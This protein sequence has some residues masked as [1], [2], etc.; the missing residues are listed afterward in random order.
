MKI[1]ASVSIV[2]LQV[3]IEIPDSTPVS[4]IR[5]KVIE[6]ARHLLANNGGEHVVLEASIAELVD[7]V[8]RLSRM[9]FPVVVEF[10][11]IEPEEPDW[12]EL[13]EYGVTR[14]QDH[15]VEYD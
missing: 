5:D 7:G 4:E 15:R 12:N 6:Q 14:S 11:E 8:G 9:G 3:I 2:P 13:A 1:S 10:V